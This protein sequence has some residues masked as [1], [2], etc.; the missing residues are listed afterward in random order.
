MK[1]ISIGIHSQASKILLSIIR[2]RFFRM[3]P[4]H[5]NEFPKFRGRELTELADD[6]TFHAHCL[7]IMGTFEQA[8]EFLHDAELCGAGLHLAGERHGRR[9]QQVKPFEVSEP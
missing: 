6:R 3:Y 5:Q 9:G 2:R 8:I 4:E 7:N 1:T